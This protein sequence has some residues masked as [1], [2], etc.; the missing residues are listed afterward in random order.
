[1]A[2]CRSRRNLISIVEVTCQQAGFIH[3]LVSQW[4]NIEI[5][6]SHCGYFHIEGL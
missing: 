5:F 4:L 6:T 1:M 2:S 3:H